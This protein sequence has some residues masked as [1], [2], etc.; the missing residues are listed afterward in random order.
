MTETRRL[1]LAVALGFG[2]AALPL[3]STAHRTCGPAMPPAGA[4]GYVLL[5]SSATGR[6]LRCEERVTAAVGLVP[7]AHPDEVLPRLD[8]GDIDGVI[9]DRA[10]FAAVDAAMLRDWLAA[11]DGRVLVGLG[12]PHWQVTERLGGVPVSGELTSPHLGGRLVSLVWFER[13]AAGTGGG[14]A[15]LPYVRDELAL[16]LRAAA[17]G[18][19]DGR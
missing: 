12:I 6:H 3:I 5:A 15:S 2:L 11:G 14:E 13:T 10:G 16:M 17:A 8:S 7:V 18:L 1:L 19:P 9:F 4:P